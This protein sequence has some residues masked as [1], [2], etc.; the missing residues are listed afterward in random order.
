MMRPDA[1]I[2]TQVVIARMD[3]D[4]RPH[5]LEQ[6]D[7][8]GAPQRIVLDQ[9]EM[10]IG[11]AEDAGIRLLSQRASR[12]HAVLARRGVEYAIRD[13][14]SRNGIFLNGV[15]VHS[16]VLRDGDIIQIADCVFT[17]HEG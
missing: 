4:V 7:G 14:D 12:H 2:S 16:A 1:T 17:Y 13:N 11:R 5:H 8:E 9:P 15:K 3:R 10:I 6:I